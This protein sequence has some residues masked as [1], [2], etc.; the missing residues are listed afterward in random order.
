[1][2]GTSSV[3]LQ[4][5]GLASGEVKYNPLARR[6]A[7]L[8][9]RQDATCHSS[10][11]DEDDETVS[12]SVRAASR[13]RHNA[14]LCLTR[15]HAS[16]C[17]RRLLCARTT[18][19]DAMHTRRV[20][21]DAQ[22][23]LHRQHASN[24]RHRNLKRLPP[25][26]RSTHTQQAQEFMRQQRVIHDFRSERCAVPRLGRLLVFSD[27]TPLP[28]VCALPIPLSHQRRPRA[29]GRGN[30]RHPTQLGVRGGVAVSVVAGQLGAV[31]S[32]MAVLETRS[33]PL[34]QYPCT[35]STMRSASPQPC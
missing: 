2:A 26:T 7:G 30:E 19:T 25:Q 21:L 20:W 18:P 33:L 10:E 28:L 17:A 4:P 8:K 31:S 13:W 24:S 5:E 11:D 12:R 9:S 3:M 15:R 23:Q 34:T 16:P 6:A 22:Q 32:L 14:M 35:G 27:L 29:R 1:M